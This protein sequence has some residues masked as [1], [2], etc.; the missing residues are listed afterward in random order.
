MKK[1]QIIYKIKKI[2]INSDYNFKNDKP[3]LRELFNNYTDSLCKNGLITDYQYNNIILTDR[4]LKSLLSLAD[5]L[6]TTLFNGYVNEPKTGKIYM[7]T[8]TNKDKCIANGN[9]WNESEIKQ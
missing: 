2:I 9:T 8:G 7:L 4:D 1:E 3:A 5:K 6:N